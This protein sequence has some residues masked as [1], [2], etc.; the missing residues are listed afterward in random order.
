MTAASPPLQ[1]ELSQCHYLVDLE[2]PRETPLE[3]RY[4]LDT[5]HWEVV[6]RQPFLDAVR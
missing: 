6:V 4:S 3:P 5:Q 2:V 1:F